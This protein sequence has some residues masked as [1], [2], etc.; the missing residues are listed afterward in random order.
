MLKIAPKAF[1]SE[2]QV[3]K[4]VMT[5]TSSTGWKKEIVYLAIKKIQKYKYILQTIENKCAVPYQFEASSKHINP[6]AI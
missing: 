6:I 5:V 3:M 4:E 2:M 1:S